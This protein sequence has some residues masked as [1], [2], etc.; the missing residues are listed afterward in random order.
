MRID[1]SII[2]GPIGQRIIAERPGLALVLPDGEL[3]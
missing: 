3:L 1:A 2:S